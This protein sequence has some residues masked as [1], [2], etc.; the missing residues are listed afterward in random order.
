MSR[1][2]HNLIIVLLLF[3]TACEDKASS[4]ADNTLYDYELHSNNRVSSL[5]MTKNEYKNWSKKVIKFKGKD[6][7]SITQLAKV[8][9]VNAAT[10]RD[11]IEK[12]L[13]QVFLKLA[14]QLVFSNQD[15]V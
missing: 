13:P 11:R 1:V 4:D 10:L 7:E 5:L 3:F 12:K 15:F 6:Y 9:G 14:F 2:L 8:L